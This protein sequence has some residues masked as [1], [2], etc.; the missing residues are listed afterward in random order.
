MITF[1]QPENLVSLADSLCDLVNERKSTIQNSW[2]FS[3]DA[4]LVKIYCATHSDILL[5]SKD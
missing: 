2:K 1:T 5:G 4:P 3:L